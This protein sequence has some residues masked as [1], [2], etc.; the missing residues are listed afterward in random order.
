MRKALAVAAVLGLAG[1]A[2]ADILISEILGSTESA[3]R[4]YI[5]I[6]NTGNTAVDLTGWALELWDSDA[7][8]SFGG[9]DGGS[10]YVFGTFI[11]NPGA[12]FTIGNTLAQ[13]AY[14]DPPYHFDGLLQDNA[15]ENSS[16]TAVLVDAS[17]S[18]VDA[19]FVTDGGAG[20][21]ANRAGAA[22]SV[23]LTVGPDGTFLPAGFARTD[24]V[25]GV[26]ILN[27]NYA[28]QAN[29]T[30]EGGTPGINQLIPA[31]GTVALLG[32]GGLAAIRRR[33]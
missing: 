6:V 27:F 10:P 19:V 18:I 7:G 11:L 17:N 33:R 23:S 20:D 14:S 4:E 30:I 32:F 28:D 16:Y 12:V 13:G 8:A 1:A 5:E 22:I 2:Q 24:A 31:P 15:V 25:G 29:G 3:D 26:A 9:A 21:A